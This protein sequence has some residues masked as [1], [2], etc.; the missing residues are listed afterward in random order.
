MSTG[1]ETW[2]TNLFE[3]VELYPFAGSEMVMAVAGIV[4]W[5][6]WHLIQIRSESQTLAEE[7]AAFHDKEKLA[8][9]RKLGNAGTVAD[10]ARA[11]VDGV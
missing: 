3:V 11:H 7:D 4:A 9:A 8:A 5:I 10:T 1:I 2:N 6:I